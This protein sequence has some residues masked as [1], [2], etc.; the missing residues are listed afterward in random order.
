MST[1]QRCQPLADTLEMTVGPITLQQLT[2]LITVTVE[3]VLQQRVPPFKTC[4][5]ELEPQAKQPRECTT[6]SSQMFNKVYEHF[7]ETSWKY[8]DLLSTEI[9]VEELST[10]FHPPQMGEYNNSSDPKG[11]LCRFENVDLLNQYSKWNEVDLSW[12]SVTMVDQHWRYL[13]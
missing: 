8:K 9:L 5:E 7:Q 10:S 6:S 3:E 4:A 1:S 2:Q 13:L 12:A 11:H